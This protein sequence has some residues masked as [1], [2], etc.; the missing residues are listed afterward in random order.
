VSLDYF[1][2][3][4]TALRDRQH[5]FWDEPFVENVYSAAILIQKVEYI[6]N[7][8]INKGWRLVEERADYWA[9]SA[10]Y[11]DRDAAPVIPVDDVRLLL[12]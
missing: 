9:S 5:R 12:E 3:Q 1:A 7:N 2:Q 11:Y 8:P 10:C 4:A 6:H